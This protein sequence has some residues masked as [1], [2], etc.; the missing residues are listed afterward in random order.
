MP[1][2]EAPVKQ[3]EPDNEALN[4]PVDMLELSSRSLNCLKAA[5]IKTIGELASK[6]EKELSMVKNFGA[7]SLQE[8]QERLA[9]MKLKLADNKE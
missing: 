2:E 4:Q 5:N 1:Q 6:T 7:R 8:V 9:A 3:E